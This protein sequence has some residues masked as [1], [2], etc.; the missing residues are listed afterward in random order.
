MKQYSKWLYAIPALVGV[1]LIY[2]QIKKKKAKP[3]KLEEVVIPP[4]SVV[5]GV[6]GGGGVS[7]VYPL[8]IGSRNDTVELLQGILNTA[9]PT[10]NPVMISS[11]RT[12]DKLVV[13]G[14][15]GPKTEEALSVL[16]GKKQIN[17]PTEFQFVVDKV[18]NLVPTTGGVGFNPYP[19]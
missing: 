12:I 4:I 7:S 3:I 16:T 15:F 2:I 14:D 19:F 10:P 11:K 1:Y 6:T 8:K 17:N 13:D 18:K 9:L 5:G